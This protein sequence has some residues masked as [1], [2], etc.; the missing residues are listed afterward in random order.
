MIGIPNSSMNS[1]EVGLGFVPKIGWPSHRMIVRFPVG[2]EERCK[3]ATVPVAGFRSTI[4][5]ETAWAREPGIVVRLSRA[6][7]GC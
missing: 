6:N 5:V 3:A 7:G 1:K 4:A 2:A